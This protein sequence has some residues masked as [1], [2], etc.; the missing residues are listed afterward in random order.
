MNKLVPIVHEMQP[1]SAN[2]KIGSIV[3]YDPLNDNYGSIAASGYRAVQPANYTAT[4]YYGSS[5]FSF[6]SSIF[7]IPF[8]LSSSHAILFFL[9]PVMPFFFLVPVM[10][11]FFLSSSHAILF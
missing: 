4:S 5:I 8:F 6:S 3:D 11:F 9:V 2:R 10:P 1:S 7:A